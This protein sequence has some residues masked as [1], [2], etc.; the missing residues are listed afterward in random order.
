MSQPMKHQTLNRADGFHLS[1]GCHHAALFT[2]V[3]TLLLA[4]PLGLSA[5]FGD[6]PGFAV[7]GAALS[8]RAWGP[9]PCWE[10]AGPPQHH[11]RLALS[12]GTALCGPWEA[13]L[14]GF[15]GAA[16]SPGCCN[17]VEKLLNGPALLLRLLLETSWEC[18]GHVGQPRQT[19]LQLS[20]LKGV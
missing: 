6:L 8:V 2:Q 17:L 9:E 10:G 11:G 7:R 20:A 1:G 15:L 3:P 12:P 4:A 14:A 16:C 5:P 18:L 13:S 19:A